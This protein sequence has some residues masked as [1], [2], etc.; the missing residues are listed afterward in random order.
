MSPGMAASRYIAFLRAINVGGHGLVKMSDLR[1]AFAAAG[2]SGV[3]TYIQSGN[4]V[5]DVP[6]GAADKI[7]ER[8]HAGLQALLGEDPVVIYRLAKALDRALASDPFKGVRAD[9]SVKRYATFLVEKPKAMPKL[10]FLWEKEAVEV[11]AIKG[12]DLFVVTRP[13]KDGRHGFPNLSVEKSLGVLATSRNVNTLA[14]VVDLAR[15]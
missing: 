7:F 8:I 11:V 6:G 12:L 1:D 13:L 15:D 14:K 4:V 10:P 5:F 2:A 9:P 3:K